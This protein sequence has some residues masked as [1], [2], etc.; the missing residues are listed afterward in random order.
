MESR[1]KNRYRVII[2]GA[3]MAGISAAQ[4]LVKNGITD[5]AILEADNR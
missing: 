3:G 4:H 1:N 2:V 5:I